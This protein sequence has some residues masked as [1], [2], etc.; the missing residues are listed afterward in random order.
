MNYGLWT[1]VQKKERKQNK[2][3]LKSSLYFNEILRTTS[4]TLAASF[5]C[6]NK[7]T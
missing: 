5:L 7:T 1:S 4:R 6:S 3:I 2:T